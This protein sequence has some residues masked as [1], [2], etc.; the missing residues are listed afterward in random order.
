VLACQP[1]LGIF[2]LAAIAPELLVAL[3]SSLAP[4]VP[5]RATFPFLEREFKQGLLVIVS[6]D[7]PPLAGGFR[8]QGLAVQGS[9]I[10][11]LL[12][13]FCCLHFSARSIGEFDA[14]LVKH[15]QLATSDVEVIAR[16]ASLP[17]LSP[18]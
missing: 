15:G 13:A 17:L 10:H 14:F 11:D 1:L 18:I 16:H 9:P 3:W 7:Y 5:K 4:S 2:D 6:N 8:V 12:R